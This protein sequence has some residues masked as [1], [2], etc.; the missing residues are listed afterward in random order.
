MKAFEGQ[1]DDEK[2]LMVFR[3]HPIAM[4]KG[5]YVLLVPFLLA[6]LPVLIWPGELAL[7]WVAL[8]GFGL[9]LL[10][11]AYH[12]V[13]W[14]YSVFIVTNYRVR[15][16]VQEG[17]F[18]RNIS[19]LDLDKAQNISMEVPGLNASLFGFGTIVVQTYVG[20]VVWDKLHKPEETYNQLIEIVNRYGG[21]SGPLG[22]NE[23]ISE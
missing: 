20:S 7:L 15:Q 2:L 8:G 21:K 23:T 13:C 4:R 12:Y 5:F 10:G 16:V 1:H 11:F 14:Y 9:G 17:L 6:S 22:K 19:D 18:K 3:H